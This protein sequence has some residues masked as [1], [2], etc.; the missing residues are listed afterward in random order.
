MFVSTNFLEAQWDADMYQM[1][2]Q[3]LVNESLVKL[4]WRDLFHY[5]I[6]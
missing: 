5:I 6:R 4:P 3:C 2:N 1:L